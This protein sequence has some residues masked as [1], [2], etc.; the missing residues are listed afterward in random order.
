MPYIVKFNKDNSKHGKSEAIIFNFHIHAYW[1]VTCSWF[2]R[3]NSW[4]PKLLTQTHSNPKN[5]DDDDQSKL[6]MFTP[7][8]YEHQH[9]R[10]AYTHASMCTN[11]HIFT[12]FVTSKGSSCFIH[13][14]SF[15]TSVLSQQVHDY[16]TKISIRWTLY[17]MCWVNILIPVY[18][19]CLPEQVI[20]P[21]WQRVNEK[22]EW[23]RESKTENK[24][25]LSLWPQVKNFPDVW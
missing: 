2:S 21:L 14:E 25:T 4:W 18:F 20:Q 5:N 9:L 12:G 22:G 3:L 6:K 19:S 23:M 15:S 17:K 24:R 7:Q 10:Y 16:Q 8:I 11:T 1:Q 13:K